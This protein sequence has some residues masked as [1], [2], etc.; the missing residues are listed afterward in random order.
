MMRE[1]RNLSGV[2]FLRS[3]TGDRGRSMVLQV[4]VGGRPDGISQMVS[5][6]GDPRFG[7]QSPNRK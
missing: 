2:G 6:T 1:G 7:L 3:K 5:V 4:L